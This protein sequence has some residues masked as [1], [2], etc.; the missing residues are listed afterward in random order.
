MMQQSELLEASWPYQTMDFSFDGVELYGLDMYND[1]LGSLEFLPSFLSTPENSSEISSPN[2]YFS[3]GLPDDS[4]G[5]F[6]FG[7][8]LPNLEE[9]S[10]SSKEKGGVV[11][12]IISLSDL[13]DI[14]NSTPSQEILSNNKDLVEIPSAQL[15]LIFPQEDIELDIQLSVCNL[16]KAYGEAME[17][18][19]VDLV[20][21]ILARL[22]EKADPT[23]ETFQRLAY[24]LVQSSDKHMDYLKQESFKIYRPAFLAFYQIFPYGR[25]A[26]FLANSE[27]LN[28]VPED[29]E[30]IVIV[31]FDIGEGLQWPSLIELLGRRKQRFVVRLISIKWE[32][33]YF[34]SA[35]CLW[36]FEE[37]KRLLNE[38]ADSFN[39]K[40]EIEEMEM[41]E[42]AREMKM[43][44]KSG[45]GNEWKAFNCMANLPH[46]GRNRCTSHVNEFLEIAKDSI[47][48]KGS[49][50]GGI[51]T[52]GDGLMEGRKGDFDGFGA[53]LEGKLAHFHA[54]LESM[55]L[56][57]P[58]QLI[59]ARIAMECLFVAPY[60][61][62]H[63]CLQRWEGNSVG[64]KGFPVIGLESRKLNKDGVDEVKELVRQGESQYWVRN[65]AE[66]GNEMVLGYMGIPLVGFS[67]WK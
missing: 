11:D 54:L 64:K 10:F 35:P 12:E 27:I 43:M 38:H 20:E 9:S 3:S 51:V 40:L 25:F 50:S 66:N 6:E 49:T 30:I 62:S 56:H 2:Q 37:T 63:A 45:G 28:A 61:S 57:F 19:Q 17:N 16:I 4:Y 58:P 55:D 32:E 13:M 26:H 23:G 52:F 33:N 48:K 29:A 46:M 44:R 39:L 22:E 14:D 7:Q 1:G 60:F 18:G 59:E 24:Y 8:F 53:F 65:E 41:E 67:S 47:K 34:S 5:N 21:A 36:K 31:D 15:S 42:L